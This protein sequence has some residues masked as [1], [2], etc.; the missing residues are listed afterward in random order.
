M[1][2]PLPPRAGRPPQLWRLGQARHTRLAHPGTPGCL[3]PQPTPG[4]CPQLQQAWRDPPPPPQA[5]WLPTSACGNWDV[6]E[7]KCTHT[8]PQLGS[9]LAGNLRELRSGAQRRETETW[10][11]GSE[12]G[13][14]S[15]QAAEEA[16]QAK[17]EGTQ[18]SCPRPL[19]PGDGTH[20]KDEDMGE[21][22]W[23]Q[24]SAWWP[25]GLGREAG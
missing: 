15:G 23:R 21:C 24:V 11:K 17:G 13:I 14:E 16:A 22:G 5:W 2:L 4:S 7:T 20:P 12:E 6:R 8:T 3:Q 9:S 18:H 19:E 1:S 10:G 25:T